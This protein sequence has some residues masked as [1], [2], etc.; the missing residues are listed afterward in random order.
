[1]NCGVFD[2]VLQVGVLA[3]YNFIHFFAPLGC[4]SLGL[5]CRDSLV[6]KVNPTNN[7][8]VSW[9]SGYPLNQLKVDFECKRSF[10]TWPDVVLDVFVDSNSKFTSK[11]LKDLIHSN[12]QS[13]HQLQLQLQLQLKPLRNLKV[14]NQHLSKDGLNLTTKRS[15]QHQPSKLL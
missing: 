12:Y 14:K 7:T 1:M 6:F 15:Y 10:E 4:P 11:K 8:G 3:I 13:S 9:L 2:V 5:L